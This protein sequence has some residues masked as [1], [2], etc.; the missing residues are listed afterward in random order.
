L[1]STNYATKTIIRLPPSSLYPMLHK[2]N[3]R[4]PP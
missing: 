3:L 4:T 1:K 2:S